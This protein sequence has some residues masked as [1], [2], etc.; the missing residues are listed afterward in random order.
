MNKCKKGEP[1][2]HY[3]IIEPAGEIVSDL[4]PGPPRTPGQSLGRC[5]NCGWERL[6]INYI[7]MPVTGASP[8]SKAN[9]ATA[10]TARADLE[11][12]ASGRKGKRRASDG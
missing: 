2:P 5:Q 11:L 10:R 3:W 6:H 9:A 12:G 7:P 4:V 8:A 1:G